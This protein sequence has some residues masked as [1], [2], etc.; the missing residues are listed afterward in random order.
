MLMVKS[1]KYVLVIELLVVYQNS[2][3]QG[4]PAPN[5]DFSSNYITQKTKGTELP[6][7]N[8]ARERALIAV[9]SIDEL[10]RRV[11]RNQ[12]KYKSLKSSINSIQR[13]IDKIIRKKR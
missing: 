7:P 13:E 3:A 9:K 12:K 11:E 5:I 1:W 2:E 4:L 10:T 8:Y 6:T